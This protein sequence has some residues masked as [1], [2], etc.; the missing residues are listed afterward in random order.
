MMTEKI[1]KRKE[2]FKEKGQEMKRG[3]GSHIDLESRRLI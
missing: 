3:D 1:R 2:G